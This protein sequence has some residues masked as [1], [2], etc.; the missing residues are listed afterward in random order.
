VI[1]N[2]CSPAVA[3]GEMRLLTFAHTLTLFASLYGNPSAL[4]FLPVCSAKI[5]V[6]GRTIS[7]E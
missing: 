4:P 3:L 6:L 2:G 1:V 5:R 7:R